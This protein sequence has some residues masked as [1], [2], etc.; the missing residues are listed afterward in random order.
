[1]REHALIMTRVR[2][3]TE[4]A[5]IRRSARRWASGWLLR[6]IILAGFWLYLPLEAFDADADTGL[7]EA[8]LQSAYASLPFAR[9]VPP[10]PHTPAGPPRRDDLFS[11]SP[12]GTTLLVTDLTSRQDRQVQ[13]LVAS[14]QCARSHIEVVTYPMESSES[15]SDLSSRPF[16]ERHAVARAVLF[17]GDARS[18]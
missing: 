1:M 4:N 5:I 12:R 14:R 13:H 7:D 3:G 16:T 6:L 9:S 2:Q 10:N 15:V 18:R 11:M 8:V 17:L